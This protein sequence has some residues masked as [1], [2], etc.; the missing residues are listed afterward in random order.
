MQIEKVLYLFY[1]SESV[2][3]SVVFDSLQPC[4]LQP[5]RLLCPWD[6]PGTTI[7]VGC[8]ALLQG[9]FPTQGSNPGLLHYRQILYHLS[10]QGSFV[11]QKPLVCFRGKKKNT[12]IHSTS[13]YCNHRADS[14]VGAYKSYHCSLKTNQQMNHQC[15]GSGRVEYSR[16]EMGWKVGQCRHLLMIANSVT[17]Q[18][19]H[20]PVTTSHNPLTIFLYPIFQK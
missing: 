8:H 6:S 19:K 18:K 2:S 5:T 7:G 13:S 15:R 9:I 20:I 4:R 14:P 16:E 11:Q 17:M 10:H 1:E 12:H 3:H